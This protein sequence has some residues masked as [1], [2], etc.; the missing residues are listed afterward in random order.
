VSK[1]ET[2]R[3]HGR[4]KHVTVKVKKTVAEALIM[5]T[6]LTGQNGAKITQSTKISVTGCKK[7]T[8]KKPVKKHAKTKK[9][10]GK[11]K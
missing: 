4:V 1:K 11:K 9:A 7:T 2:K 3:V 8:V 5:P 10:S 6:E